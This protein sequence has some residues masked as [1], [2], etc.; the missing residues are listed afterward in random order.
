MRRSDPPRTRI[1]P[2]ETNTRFCESCP[3]LYHRRS[4]RQS[5]GGLTEEGTEALPPVRAG[6]L[7]EPGGIE[8]ACDVPSPVMA[9][10]YAHC[11]ESTL[12]P[13][14]S[15][16]PKSRDR[17]APL[18]T[19]HAL[20]RQNYVFLRIDRLRDIS[21]PMCV[22]VGRS[23]NRQSCKEEGQASLCPCG[24][25]AFCRSL[26]PSAGWSAGVIERCTRMSNSGW[27]YRGDRVGGGWHSYADRHTEIT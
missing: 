23:H 21:Y 7:G 3:I 9:D 12:F 4:C 15:G 13:A 19:G 26:Q 11:R 5:A 16:G 1:S 6:V 8:M 10:T 18:T 17:W 25:Y 20:R 24:N 22:S 14:S 27:R 2:A